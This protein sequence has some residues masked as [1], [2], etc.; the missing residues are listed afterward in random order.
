MASLTISAIWQMRV[1]LMRRS[2]VFGSIKLSFRTTVKSSLRMLEG[3]RPVSPA[4]SRMCVSNA[5]STDP[6][7]GATITVLAEGWRFLESSDTII[8]GRGSLSG[9][10][11][12]EFYEPDF[13]ALRNALHVR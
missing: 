6:V 13:A 2:G 12:R 7:I 8:T 11:G 3:Y 4:D 10:V 9:G 1:L 5:F